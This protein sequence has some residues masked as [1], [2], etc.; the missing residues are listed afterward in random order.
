MLHKLV[1]TIFQLKSQANLQRDGPAAR[2]AGQIMS[3]SS[4]DAWLKG[5]THCKNAI[6]TFKLTRNELLGYLGG[7]ASVLPHS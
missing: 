2:L 6:L 5:K 4:E 7:W 1:G 3:N